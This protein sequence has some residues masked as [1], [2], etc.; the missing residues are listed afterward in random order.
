MDWT[1]TRQAGLER[2]RAFVPHAGSAY[3]SGRNRDEGWEPSAG[4]GP[5]SRT[6]VS[7]LS[8]WIQRRLVLESEVVRAVTEA[9][10]PAQPEKFVQEV[11]WRTYWKGWLAMRPSVW[12]DYLSDCDRDAQRVESN[13][14]AR[15][16]Y[17]RACDGETGLACFDHWSAELRETGYLHNHAR[18]WFASIWTF[19]LGLPWTL[20]AAWFERHLLDADAASNTLSWRWVA[21]LHTRGKHYVARAENIRRFTGGRFDPTGALARAPAALH[22]DREHPREPIVELPEAPNHSDVRSGLLLTTEDLCP[23]RSALRDTTFVSVAGGLPA[24][25][26]GTHGSR[27]IQFHA[28]S[29][30]D[31]L[32]RSATAFAAAAVRLPDGTDYLDGVL[33][34]AHEAALQRVVA[35]APTV[36]RWTASFERL[37]TRLSRSG[38]ELALCRRAW[39]TQLYP[40]ATAGYFKFKKVIPDLL[41]RIA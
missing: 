9:H 39:D 37:A 5:D 26:T 27:P 32:Q 1:P 28:A 15:R 13:G 30:H 34:W 3:A 33:A 36:G 40:H 35:H 22:D 12:A 18:M 2:L 7:G 4:A 17:A 25:V 23:E 10:G 6:T 19:T 21:G 20:G 29:L 38:I 11:L 31:G 24:D 41:R 8:P 14:R 16:A